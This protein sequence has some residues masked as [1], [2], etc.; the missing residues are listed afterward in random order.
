MPKRVSPQLKERIQAINQDP[1]LS[2]TEKTDMVKLII[3]QMLQR[4]ETIVEET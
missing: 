4:N 2:A 3:Q 1:D